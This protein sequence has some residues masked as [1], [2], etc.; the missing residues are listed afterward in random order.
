MANYAYEDEVKWSDDTDT[1]AMKLDMLL[2]LHKGADFW[3]IPAFGREMRKLPNQRKRQ[4]LYHVKWLN[5][6]VATWEP[7]SVLRQQVP[8]VVG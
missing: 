5:H 7:A 6:R 4:L 1:R 3:M 2:D 8:Q